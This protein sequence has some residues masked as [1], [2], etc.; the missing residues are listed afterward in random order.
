MQVVPFRIRTVMRL[1][2]SL[3]VRCGSE[4]LAGRTF[5]VAPAHLLSLPPPRPRPGLSPAVSSSQKC[6]SRGELQVSLSYQPVAQRLT[7]VV[8]KARHL[9]K[10]DITGLSGSSYL[11]R[12]ASGP[13]APRRPAR[14]P[15]CPTPFGSPP[16]LCARSLPCDYL[17]SRCPECRRC[18]G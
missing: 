2:V 4:T 15:T 7:V 5:S 12:P 1:S 6:I 17:G 8:L 9:P 18:P 11:P 13:L 10:M 3:P 14:A 16:L